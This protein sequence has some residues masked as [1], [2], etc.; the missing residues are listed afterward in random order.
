MPLHEAR[1]CSGLCPQHLHLENGLLSSL[2]IPQHSLCKHFDLLEA[3]PES[4][5]SPRPELARGESNAF[6]LRVSEASH[7]AAHGFNLEGCHQHF[8]KGN[9]IAESPGIARSEGKRCSANFFFPRCLYVSAHASSS[10]CKVQC[11]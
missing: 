9:G 11:F 5:T 7:L 3:L 6:I 8:Q 4:P 1:S 10:G 2:I